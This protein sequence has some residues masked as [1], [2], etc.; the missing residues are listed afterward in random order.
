M[1]FLGQGGVRSRRVRRRGGER[2]QRHAEVASQGPS[3]FSQVI[4]WKLLDDTWGHDGYLKW[5]MNLRG[6]YTGKRDKLL[7]AC[8]EFLPKELVSWVPPRAGMF[9]SF[10]PVPL[11]SETLLTME[12]DVA[13]G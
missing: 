1:C 11:F 4:L 5:L 2:Y 9:V 8:E 12:I 3:G 13:Q 7:R 10:L 6:E